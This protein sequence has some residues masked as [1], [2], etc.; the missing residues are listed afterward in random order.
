[1]LDDIFEIVFDVIMGQVPVVILKILLLLV[2][3]AA[4]A[5]GVPLLADS[6]LVGGALTALGAAAAIG[7]IVSWAL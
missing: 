6:P 3:L 2:G 1:M 7:V 4:V 5:V